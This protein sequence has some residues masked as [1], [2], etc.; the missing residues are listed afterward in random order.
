M[1]V[2]VVCIVAVF[3]SSALFHVLVFL[4]GTTQGEGEGERNSAVSSA[5]QSTS[6]QAQKFFGFMKDGAG[7]FFKNIKESSSKA[8]SAMSA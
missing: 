8:L 7:S 5:L 1:K 2:A 3:F 6:Q 4:I